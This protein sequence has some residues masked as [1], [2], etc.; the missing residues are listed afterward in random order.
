MILMMRQWA[1][2]LA[3]QATIGGDNENHR[4]RAEAIDGVIFQIIKPTSNKTKR[5]VIINGI[6]DRG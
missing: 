1:I 5:N 2:M 4:L 3:G 6:G